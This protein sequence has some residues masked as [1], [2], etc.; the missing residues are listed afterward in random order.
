MQGKLHAAVHWITE[1]EMGG[2]LLPDERDGKTGDT[3][4][5]IKSKRPEARIPD[6]KK[7]T[8]SALNFWILI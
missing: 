8:K 7:H 2:I 1:R 6:A 3:V 5:V 4:Q